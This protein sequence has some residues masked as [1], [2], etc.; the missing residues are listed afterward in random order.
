MPSVRSITK[1][2]DYRYAGGN[3]QMDGTD[4]IKD[5]GGDVVAVLIQYRLGVFG[6]Q[7]L[8]SLKLKK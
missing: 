2:C 5:A 3:A 6:K 4:L 7:V 8:Y 1:N